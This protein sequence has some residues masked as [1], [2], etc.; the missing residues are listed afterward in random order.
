MTANQAFR[1][2]RAVYGIQFHFEADTRLVQEWTHVFH[3]QIATNHAQ[4]LDDF[5]AHAGRHGTAADAAGLELARAWVKLI[6]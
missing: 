2:G 6:A 3:D 4:W 1:I 5:E